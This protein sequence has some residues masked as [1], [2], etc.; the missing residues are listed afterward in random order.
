MH[1]DLP[2]AVMVWEVTTKVSV[3]DTIFFW[4]GGEGV[5]PLLVSQSLSSKILLCPLYRSQKESSA[6]QQ[7][8]R[9]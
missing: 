4:G 6:D 8:I 1:H 9:Q 3:P 5:I 2:A 7:K